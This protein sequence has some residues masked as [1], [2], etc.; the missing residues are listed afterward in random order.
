[1]GTV[2]CGLAEFGG[3]REGTVHLYACGRRC[4]AHAP[5]ALSGRGRP[6]TPRPD[7]TAAGLQ[8][9][10]AAEYDHAAIDRQ[11]MINA[12]IANR[13]HVPVPSRLVAAQQVAAEK[14]AARDAL[15]AQVRQEAR[16]RTTRNVA[17]AKATVAQSKAARDQA[18]TQV[19]T[20]AP[21]DW[22][23][24]ARR[25]IWHLATTGKPYDPA[26]RLGGFTTDDVWDLLEQRGVEQPPEPRALGPIIMAAVRKH[27]IRDTDARRPS[28]R[29]HSTRINIYERSHPA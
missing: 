16:T 4:D 18:M 17:A 13:R 12:A 3:C 8:A 9:W 7:W 20:A 26:T 24:Q 15:R 27:A 28:R 29:R 25:A 5:W 2:T 6:P 11:H 14:T 22:K 23:D 10:A 21:D 19:D 1:M